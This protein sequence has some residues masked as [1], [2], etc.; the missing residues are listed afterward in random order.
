MR[1]NIRGIR[2]SILQLYFCLIL[3]P[4]G[5]HNVI[6]RRSIKSILCYLLSYDRK[7]SMNC[8]CKLHWIITRIN[9]VIEGRYIENYLSLLVSS[10]FLKL[11]WIYFKAKVI[12]KAK[13]LGPK[14]GHNR[15]LILNT[16]LKQLRHIRFYLP[17]H[18]L[19]NHR[20]ILRWKL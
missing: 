1:L 5:V 7:S 19:Y 20:K 12:R 11:L 3:I 17:K 15:H 9:C 4:Q 8:R 16:Q 10:K 18:P 13:L 14:T 2:K 6:K